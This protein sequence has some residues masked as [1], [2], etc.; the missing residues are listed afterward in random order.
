MLPRGLNR[1]RQFLQSEETH[2]GAGEEGR[3]EDERRDVMLGNKKK[4]RLKRRSWDKK[5]DE[6]RKGAVRSWDS[7]SAV[8]SSSTKK[9]SMM[10][11]R[12]ESGVRKE[13][14]CC[15]TNISTQIPNFMRETEAKL[16][17]QSSA[18]CYSREERAKT[19]PPTRFRLSVTGSVRKES[20]L[21]PFKRGESSRRIPSTRR[22]SAPS[23]YLQV[24]RKPHPSSLS[25]KVIRAE[26]LRWWVSI[27]KSVST[28][29]LRGRS[30]VQEEE[31][32]KLQVWGEAEWNMRGGKQN[33]AT[34]VQSEGTLRFRYRRGSKNLRLIRR[35]AKP[36]D[37][38]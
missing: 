37:W 23:R 20:D 21:S 1:F 10:I 18:A 5:K 34:K 36:L 28:I 30:T 22:R 29:S 14:G 3:L 25:R 4:T 11:I 2:I 17:D 6:K 35:G 38:G 15:L 31:G 33:Q 9:E 13:R 7:H 32:K 12:L 26:R 8:R 16:Y 27:R 24:N 19:N